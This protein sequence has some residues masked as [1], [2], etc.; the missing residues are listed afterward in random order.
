MGNEDEESRKQ[1]DREKEKI[2]EQLLPFNG[3]LKV[4]CAGKGTQQQQYKKIKTTYAEKTVGFFRARGVLSFF[5]TTNVIPPVN[6]A[7]ATGKQQTKTR[8]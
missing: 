7:K 8:A 6:K 3:V 2:F 1:N 4:K 5:H